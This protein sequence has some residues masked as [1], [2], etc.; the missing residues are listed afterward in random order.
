MKKII[1]GLSAILALGFV[2]PAVAMDVKSG[3]YTVDQSGCVTSKKE[4]PAKV[5]KPKKEKPAK[6]EKAKKVK[7][8]KDKK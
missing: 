5:D 7:V 2:C 8:K 3:T 4:K 1:L 6:I